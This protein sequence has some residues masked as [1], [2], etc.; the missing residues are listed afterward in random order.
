MASALVDF[1]NH[2]VGCQP[3]EAAAKWPP[4][5]DERALERERVAAGN[6]SEL[7]GT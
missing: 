7:L 1:H 6:A 3:S 2:F 5:A 4:L